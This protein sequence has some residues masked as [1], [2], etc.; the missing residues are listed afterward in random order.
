MSLIVFSTRSLAP[1]RAVSSVVSRLAAKAV[2]TAGLVLSA[3]SV[4]GASAQ[5]VPLE[6][7]LVQNYTVI[8]QLVPA[9]QASFLDENGQPVQLKDFEGQVTLL[10]F[11]ATW[12]AP[13]V[14]E[15]PSLDRLQEKAG[16]DKLRVV[17]VSVDRGDLSVPREFFQKLS[18]NHLDVYKDDN[19]QLAGAFKLQVMPSTFLIN[20][21][22]N[23]VGALF[24][25][26]EWDRPEVLKLVEYYDSL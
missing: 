3:F 7:Q 10:N 24:G 11:W 18:L 21:A 17:T 22:G 23:V 19:N 8:D 12:C 13:C 2:V 15:M 1:R 16:K 20:K 5:S 26:F 9:P 25:P 14:K 4:Q 6:G